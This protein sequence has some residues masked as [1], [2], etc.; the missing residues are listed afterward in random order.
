MQSTKWF[1]PVL[2]FL[3]TLS[4]M[5]GAAESG[6]ISTEAEDRREIPTGI[7]IDLQYVPARYPHYSWVD[8]Q[9]TDDSGHGLHLGVEWIPFDE[10]YG[11]LGFGVGIGVSV[12]RNIDFGGTRATMTTV[13]VELT[14]SY[15]LDYITNQIL[16]PFIKG[17]IGNTFVKQRGIDRGP[18]ANFRGASYGGGLE[19]C[20]NKLDGKTSR[21][22]HA[23]TG[24]HSTYFVAEYLRTDFLGAPQGPDL[25]RDEWRL[26]LRF[27]M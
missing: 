18:W 21:Y 23:S 15:R 20:L 14:M 12:L 7:A 9:T 27:E 6:Q 19:L 3:L 26:G 2:S 17:G 4:V 25:T 16:V 1:F 10:R 13:P 8:N 11:K 24:I 5:A 22:L